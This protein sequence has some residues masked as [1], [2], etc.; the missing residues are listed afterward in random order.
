MLLL[1]VS[2]WLCQLCSPLLGLTPPLA[3]F[4]AKASRL[5]AA[6][7]KDLSQWSLMVLF[8]QHLKRGCIHPPV[9]ILAF[10]MQRKV[11][12]TV[13][14]G[15]SEAPPS[16]PLSPVAY[17]LAACP[18]EVSSPFSCGTWHLLKSLSLPARPTSWKP[19]TVFLPLSH[20]LSRSE[21]KA[22]ASLHHGA[23]VP[24]VRL[25]ISSRVIY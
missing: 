11:L 12:E 2:A 4:S 25:N 22:D 16:Q 5:T 14:F 1:K 3:C 21:P 6:S 18:H 8:Q 20:L 13:E 19:T 10:K 23:H 15:C 24:K 17:A 7:A 9:G